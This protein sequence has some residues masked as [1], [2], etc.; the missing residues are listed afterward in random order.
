MIYFTKKCFYIVMYNNNYK[1]F[2][3]KIK[4]KNKAYLNNRINL[5]PNFK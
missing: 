5:I 3:L 1:Y 4:L 2:H